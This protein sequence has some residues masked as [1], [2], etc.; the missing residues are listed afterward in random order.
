MSSRDYISVPVENVRLDV[1][2]KPNLKED[3]QGVLTVLCKLCSDEGLIELIWKRRVGRTFPSI[4]NGLKPKNAISVSGQL[5]IRLYEE[6]GQLKFKRCIIA[7]KL[8]DFCPSSNIQDG[9]ILPILSS[10]GGEKG[11][12]IFYQHEVS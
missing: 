4:L 6:Y 2:L 3:R 9:C 10:K 8:R 7:T 5:E 11:Y 1:V 12:G